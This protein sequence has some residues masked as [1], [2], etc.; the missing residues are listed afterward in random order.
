M[1]E[2]V[3]RFQSWKAHVRE[4][5]K[6]AHALYLACRDERCPWFARLLGAG[7]IAYAL[8]PI[9][10]IPDFI[11]ILGLLDDLILV[12]LGIMLVR[13]LIPAEVLDDA[14]RRAADA[15]EEGRPVSWVAATV[16]LA[17]W[18]LLAGLSLYAVAVRL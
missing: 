16:I 14:R 7:V 10:L 15:E 6:E 17:V 13:R 12:P 11:P 8:S 18:V 5:K 3:G 2:R 4:L 1:G 9:D